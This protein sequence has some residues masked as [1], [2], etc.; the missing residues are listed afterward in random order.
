MV[1]DPSGERDGGAP[2][3]GLGEAAGPTKGFG[4]SVQATAAFSETPAETGLSDDLDR[5]LL[6]ADDP[7]TIAV[8]QL[9]S[10]C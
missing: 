6:D 8:R 3:V 4:P 9:I 10:I 5:L 1:A 2:G 7:A